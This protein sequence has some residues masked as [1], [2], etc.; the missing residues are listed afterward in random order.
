ML[1]NENDNVAL[2]SGQSRESFFVPDYW[3]QRMTSAYNIS[4]LADSQ[5]GLAYLLVDAANCGV[6]SQSWKAFCRQI[7]EWRGATGLHDDVL[8]ASD[9]DGHIKGLCVTQIVQSLLFGRILDV[10]LFVIASA[11]D[12]DGVILELLSAAKNKAREANCKDIRIW[13]QGGQSWIRAIG[14]A[15]SVTSYEG[16]QIKLGQ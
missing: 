10:P 3:R 1:K 7:I 15:T 11:G 6:D 8:V 16:V 9:R 14:G 12:E 13:T 4:R 5:I 2:R